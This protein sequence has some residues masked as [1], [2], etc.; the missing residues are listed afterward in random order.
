MHSRLT[1]AHGV[2]IIR[3]A[4]ACCTL[5]RDP[6]LA[7]HDCLKLGRIMMSLHSSFRLCGRT[8]L[9]ETPVRL[10]YALGQ[11]LALPAIQQW[12]QLR[13]A[14]CDRLQQRQNSQAASVQTPGELPG[15]PCVHS[16]SVSAHL[17][18]LDLHGRLVRGQGRWMPAWLPAGR[19][20]QAR[21]R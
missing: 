20:L 6:T 1:S 18:S 3:E 11:H 13:E 15:V 16:D 8:A 19:L 12:L 10:P 9:S 5:A 14:L 17:Q 2:A 7:W 21:S 4:G